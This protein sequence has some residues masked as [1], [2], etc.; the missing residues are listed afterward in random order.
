MKPHCLVL[1]TTIFSLAVL[2]PAGARAHGNEHGQ[3]KATIGTANVT[4]EYNRPM[5]KGRDLTKMIQPG[6]LWRI[7]AD[8]PTTL[9]SDADLDFGGTRVL[10][11]KHILLARYVEPGH[12]SLVV[13]SK[14]AHDYEP[15]AKLAEVPMELSQEAE[16]AE[17]VSIQLTESGGHGVIEIAW[18]TL[19][20]R[21][22]F[23]PAK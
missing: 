1:I 16:A 14:S 19:R 7:G 4:I 8:N 3:A 2:A 20:L 9:E 21:A 15:G 22:S 11:G 6:Q 17:M 18:G 23:V 10:K 13:S 12:W 5:L